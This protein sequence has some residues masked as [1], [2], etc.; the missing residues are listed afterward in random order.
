M[1]ATVVLTQAAEGSE[2]LFRDLSA[3]GLHVE[4]WPLVSLSTAA[5]TLD[6]ALSRL[7]DFDSI[8][9]PSPSAVR[10]VAAQM[11]RRKIAWPAG[12]RAGLVGPASVEAFRDCFGEHA[13]RGYSG[14]TAVRCPAPGGDV[15]APCPGRTEGRRTRE[16]RTRGRRTRA[17]GT[18]T[19]PSRRQDRLAR[20]TA[21]ESSVGRGRHGVRSD[22]VVRRTAA[23]TDVAPA[24]RATIG[25]GALLGGR[26]RQPPRHLVAESSRRICG[27]G[28]ASAGVC[29]A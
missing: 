20:R 22:P 1:P 25:R 18:G 6:P 14:S 8:I 19:Q 13:P 11:A 3:V 16:G 28:Q 2:S 5:K 15:R 12:T 10:L 23:R 26:R 4:R 17:A 27:L 21:R 24:A 9:L 29:A 7:A